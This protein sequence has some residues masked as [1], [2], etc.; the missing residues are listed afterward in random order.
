MLILARKEGERIRLGDDIFITIVRNKGDNVQ[1]GVDA[2]RGIVVIREE[3]AGREP[4]QQR[5]A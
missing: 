5:A 2:P 1:V 3:L 4:P